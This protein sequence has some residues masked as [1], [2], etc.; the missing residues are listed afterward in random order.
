MHE[1]K[2][3]L[4]QLVVAAEAGEEVIIERRGQPVARLVKYEQPR[5][6]RAQLRGISK[7]KFSVPDDF[8]E[9]MPAFEAAFYGE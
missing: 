9:P 6:S 1:A 3:R 2:T 8:D 4:S 7:G 5:I